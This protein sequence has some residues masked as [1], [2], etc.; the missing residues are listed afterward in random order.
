MYYKVFG[1]TIS[2]GWPAKRIG[3]RSQAVITYASGQNL[4][5]KFGSF[6]NPQLL[7]NMLQ[8]S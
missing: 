8:M 1:F 2:K 4:G 3:G 6:V 7:V 5:H